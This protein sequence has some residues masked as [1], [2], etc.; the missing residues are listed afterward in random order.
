M[1]LA[2]IILARVIIRR[3]TAQ[4]DIA[5]PPRNN[6]TPLMR[7]DVLRTLQQHYAQLW[8][9]TPGKRFMQ[10]YRRRQQKE[11]EHLWKAALYIALGSILM[12]IGLA[13][14]ALPVFPG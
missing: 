3:S 14:A 4:P 6:R 9:G 5:I 13:F 7:R 8:N 2:P 10:Y 12:L 11:K 1:A